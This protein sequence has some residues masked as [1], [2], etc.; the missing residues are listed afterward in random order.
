MIVERVGDED[1]GIEMLKVVFAL[2]NGVVITTT[3]CLVRLNP[4]IPQDV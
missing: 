4:R 1:A 2:E 3:I